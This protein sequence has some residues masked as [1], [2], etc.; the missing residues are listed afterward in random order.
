MLSR[1]LW[2]FLFRQLIRARRGSGKRPSVCRYVCRAVG[3]RGRL[4][5]TYLLCTFFPRR[6]CPNEQ[7]L[8]FA[9]SERENERD[10][11]VLP[12]FVALVGL[13]V[14][15]RRCERG[16]VWLNAVAFVD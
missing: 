14:G 1:D 13:K 11:W 16:A 10:A 2:D 7:A 4:S 9:F 8:A 5:P 15:E 6:C 12:V 3:A